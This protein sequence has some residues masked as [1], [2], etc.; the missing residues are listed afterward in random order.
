MSRRNSPGVG[1]WRD[2]IPIIS[3]PPNPKEGQATTDWY[4]YGK[5]E[6]KATGPQ[7]RGI[8]GEHHTPAPQVVPLAVAGTGMAIA[9]WSPLCYV[10]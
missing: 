5:V 10:A 4:H 1:L 8:Y 9:D 7:G 3:L 6:G 2:L